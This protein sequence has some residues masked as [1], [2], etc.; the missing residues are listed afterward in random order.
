MTRQ[1]KLFVVSGM[2]V[3]Y[4]G[5]M[6]AGQSLHELMG[7]EHDHGP[8]A[9]SKVSASSDRS[10]AVVAGEQHVHDA[11]DCPICQFQSHGQ[12]A[13]IAANQRIAT[14]S[15]HLRAAACFAGLCRPRV[16]HLQPARSSAR[17]TIC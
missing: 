5:M 12:L 2:L 16:E 15:C 1:L 4:A 13:P 11:D 14:G 3:L 7:C 9:H 17:L 6:L 10:P 8:A